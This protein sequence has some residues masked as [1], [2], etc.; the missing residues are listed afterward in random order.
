MK[1][2]FSVRTL[3]C[4]LLLALVGVGTA[5]A[6][7]VTTSAV[8]GRVTDAQGQGV[9]S[10]QVSVTNVAT[11]S[12][13]AVVTRSDGRFFIPGL[14]PGS[15]RISATGIGFGTQV[16]ENVTL[17]LGQT[18]NFDFTLAAQAVT[19]EGIT[20]TAERN[21][22]ISQSRTG[23][24]AVVSDS[25]L[26]RAPTI[27]RDLQDFTRLVPQ[28]AVTNTTTGA[29]SGGGRN[30]RFNQ[31]QID[32]TASNDLFGLS[33]SGSPSGQAG[34]KAITLEAI[35][36]LQVVLAPFDVRQNGFTGASVNAVTRSGTNRFHGSVSG[37]NRNENLVGRFTTLAD[38]ASRRLDR[39]DNTEIAGSF[40]G[41]IV[42][43]R[44][45]FFVAGE[46]TR[47][48][49]PVNVI[50]GTDAAAGI[51]MA[52]AEQVRGQ[53]ESL[54]Y[55]AGTAGGL[56]LRRESTNLFGR[57]DFNLGQNNRLT[58]R[59]NYID[60]FRED[61]S[62][63]T[64]TYQ[65]GN[66]G[67]TQNSTTNS[68]VAQLNSGFGNGLFNELRLGY[69][70]VRD[71]RSFGGDEF[72]RVDVR[73][74]N[75]SVIGG[76][77]NFSGRNVLDQD[78]FEITNDL[79]LPWRAHTF[80]VGTNNEFSQ[81][82]NLFVRNPFG[83]YQFASFA[84]FQN[85]IASRYE[86]S[87][88]C[89][90][91]LPNCP[92]AGNPRAEF[93][94]NRYSLY[95]QD[96]WDVRDNLQLTLGVRG[97]L[98]SL[99][100]RPG[101][102]PTVAAVYGRSTAEV[103]T[104]T[105]LFN[106]RF[107]FNWDVTGDQVTQIR[108]GVGVFSG[109]TPYVWISNAYGNT[110][111]DYVR[112]TCTGTQTPRFVRDPNAQPLGCTG[113]TN[114]TPNEINLIAPGFTP[115]QVARYSLAVD[116]QIPFGLIG[117][118]EGLY[119][120]TIHDVLYQNLR[121]QPDSLGRMVEGRPRYQT[122]ANTPGLGDVIDITNTD[123][124]YAYNLTAQVQRPFRA[125]WDLSLAYTFSRAMDVNPLTSSQAISNWRFNLTENDPNN[126]GLRRSD[127]DVPH[128]VLATTSYR[129]GLLRRAPTDLSLVYVGQSGQPF[130]VR[131]SDDINF[132]G[133]F[134]ND[135]LFVPAE[136]SQI[137]FEPVR[138]PR[139]RNATDPGQAI[140]PDQ[141]WQ[142]LNAFIEGV[143]CLRENRGQIISRNACRQPWSNRLDLRLA[144]NL[145]PIR[146]QNAQ[147]T[148]DILNVGNLLNQDWGRNQFV[149]NNT[150]AILPLAT[151][152]G[153]TPLPNAEGRRQYQAFAPRSEIF[154]ISNLDSRYQIQLGLRY[155]F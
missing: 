48:T 139:T 107:G 145:S 34:A 19:L 146:S 101:E 91:G 24:S 140:T 78:A 120:Q 71:F 108:G 22:V 51:T 131:Y 87:Y 96:R 66:A 154:T 70:R 141:S 76:T 88:L 79:I 41:P 23:A 82:S 103:P 100:E 150:L 32:G 86:Y 93:G 36:E 18:A 42:Q 11:G 147:I 58:L 2:V 119:T 17:S 144:Q 104:S 31:L 35:Q 68:T 132:D 109:R 30:N 72:P 12:T 38:T 99:P 136:Q 50:A 89:Q 3:L 64:S 126:P 45:F 149:G 81:F 69:N 57:L 134:G 1:P 137:R 127:F 118:L 10:A 133:S 33:A 28:L 56:D 148:V 138:A 155:T 111:L 142:N 43:N 116:R 46:S 25:T 21:D 62:R 67:Y 92:G 47:R 39:F 95:A 110:G 59:H 77:E 117:T 122:R 114:P 125:G 44:A 52:Q 124:G 83:N 129:L 102:N 85:G 106:P 98:G 9:T 13:S 60:G 14:Q 153:T 8:S 75:R 29:V 6:Q 61:F 128:R 135:L 26:R 105:F 55:E 97:D 130:S 112:F 37:F 53:L 7:A 74:G 49:A 15:Y 143:D 113:T 123:Q 80:T 90:P 63:G 27:T 84:D 121:V 115:P 16:R 54:G 20:V 5:G 40:G 65:L 4:T 94:V 152:S 73:F 151:G